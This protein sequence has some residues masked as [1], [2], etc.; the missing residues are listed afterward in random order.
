M[1]Q[2]AKF[3][4]REVKKKVK[5]VD[6]NVLRV[7]SCIYASL[8]KLAPSLHPVW[9]K[10]HILGEIIGPTLSDKKTFNCFVKKWWEVS[11]AQD[12]AKGEISTI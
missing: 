3:I 8:Y 7:L 10:S 1:N 2:K 5:Y 12:N 11:S 4:H 9:T 6:M